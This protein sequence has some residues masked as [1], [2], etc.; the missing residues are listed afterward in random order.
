MARPRG[1]KRTAA[2]DSSKLQTAAKELANRGRG[3]R[4]RALPRPIE[5]FS[6][7]RN[8]EDLWLSAFPVGTEWENID[9]LHMVNTDDI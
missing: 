6:A 7:K 5:Y 8:L 3:K 9:K 1:K 4:I 2:T